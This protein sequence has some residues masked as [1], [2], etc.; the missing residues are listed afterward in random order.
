MPS[1]LHI[2]SF[3]A[4]FALILIR[5]GLKWLLCSR[6]A[7]QNIPSGTLPISQGSYKYKRVWEARGRFQV[8]N[9]AASVA[10]LQLNPQTAQAIRRRSLNESLIDYGAFNIFIRRTA[11]KDLVAAYGSVG[12]YAFHLNSFV[13]TLPLRSFTLIGPVH[14]ALNK[15]K[16]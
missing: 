16:K 11:E 14:L 1:K 6:S 3:I 13:Y 2:P 15:G 9:S 7:N 5:K 4:T 8:G 12:V 10:P